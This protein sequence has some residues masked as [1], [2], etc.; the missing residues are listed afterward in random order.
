[1]DAKKNGTRLANSTGEQLIFAG[2]VLLYAILPE[3]TTTGTI[4]VR[5]GAVADASGAIDHIAAIGLTQ[6]GKDFK[7][8]L[9]EKGLTVQLSVGTDQCLVVW[10][11]LN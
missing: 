5:D 11:P 10:E 8:Y 4:T 7:G 3:V 9:L 1:M 2:R 6:A